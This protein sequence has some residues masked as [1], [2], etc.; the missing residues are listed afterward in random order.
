MSTALID[1]L[2]KG[3]SEE[4]RSLLKVLRESKTPE[5]I[6]ALIHVAQ[7]IKREKRTIR[8]FFLFNEAEFYDLEEQ[9]NAITALGY[10]NSIKAYKFL[11]E[12][13]QRKV[14][15]KKEPLYDKDSVEKETRELAMLS[16][17]FPN[18]RGPL[19]RSLEFNYVCAED[20]K[21]TFYDNPSGYPDIDID[22]ILY[23]KDF[24]RKNKGAYLVI[25]KALKQLKEGLLI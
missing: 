9:L 18:A 20:P 7:G 21:D 6:D 16:V 8:T 11:Y 24:A 13:I 15:V 23:S 5:A 4:R 14:I 1:L 12:L 2:R 25:R 22:N 10:T 19:V 3:D 17:A